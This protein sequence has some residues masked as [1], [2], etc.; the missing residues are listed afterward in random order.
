MKSVKTC[1]TISSALRDLDDLFAPILGVIPLQ[2]MAYHTAV[3]R[4]C[5]VDNP[6]PAKSVT[7]E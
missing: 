2:L 3:A 4:G 6:Q 1:T 5:D 7:V